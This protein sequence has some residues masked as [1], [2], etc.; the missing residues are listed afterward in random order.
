[1]DISD[2]NNPEPVEQEAELAQDDA[3]PSEQPSET[4]DENEEQQEEEPEDEELDIDG[5]PLKVPKTIAEKLKARMMMQADYTRKTQE[6][7][8]ERK[9]LQAE[10]ESFTREAE[11]NEQ[12]ADETS[13]LRWIDNRI[14]TFQ[15][16]N[17]QQLSPEDQQRALIEQMQ[18]RQAKDGLTGRITD[19][20]TELTEQRERYAANSIAKAVQALQS[21]D[22]KFGWD[23][24]FDEPK[25]KSLTQFGLELGFTQEELRNTTHPNMIKTL[26]LAKIGREALMKQKAALKAPKVEAKPV[27]QVTARK[28]TS[29]VSDPDKLS[30]EA[31]LKWREGQIARKRG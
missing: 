2:A 26:H 28:T 11:I 3:E 7:A 13:Q 25:A 8:E 30:P 5:E 22:D 6:A 24:K 14:E 29:A 4:P 18:L 17:W 31:W 21:P 27:P 10:R 19:K 9:V 20:K 15:N 16:L 23:G 1:M 12:L